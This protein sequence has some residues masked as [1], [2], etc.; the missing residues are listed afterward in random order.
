VRLTTVRLLGQQGPMA[1][2]GLAH[3]ADDENDEVRQYAARILKSLKIEVRYGGI[4]RGSTGPK[5]LALV[6]TGHEFAEGGETILDEWA[7]E[8]GLT[9]INFTP[10]TRSNADY[11]GEGD[12]NFV[13]S[14]QIFDSIVAREREDPN[15]LNGLLLL[16]HVGSGPGRADKFH[17][18]FG[19]LLDYL[20]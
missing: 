16:L 6:F 7:R 3:A 5:K 11:T 19:Q 10:G 17:T 9:L 18:R 13:S 12:R 20:T 15:G 14:Q 8:M 1:A 2:S 4:I